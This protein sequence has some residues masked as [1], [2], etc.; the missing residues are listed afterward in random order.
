MDISGRDKSRPYN[1]VSFLRDHLCL[2]LEFQLALGFFAFFR[3]APVTGTMFLARFLDTANSLKEGLLSAS[4]KICMQ[5]RIP[6]SGRIAFRS[7]NG[8]GMGGNM[9]LGMI[10][11]IFLCCLRN[12]GYGLFGPFN[13]ARLFHRNFL[14]RCFGRFGNHGLFRFFIFFRR[15]LRNLSL[16]SRDCQV[17]GCC[18]SRHYRGR[19]SGNSIRDGRRR[20]GS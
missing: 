14:F 6:V 11:R 5:L 4:K 7:R 19:L 2:L 20:Y 12:R 1:S 13:L 16:R 10:R 17:M 8:C 15:F 9:G 18:A 3:F